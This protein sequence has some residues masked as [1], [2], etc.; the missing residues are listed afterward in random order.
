[1]DLLGIKA[2][3]SDPPVPSAQAWRKPVGDREERVGLDGKLERRGLHVPAAGH[4]AHLTRKLRT[5]FGWEVL[6]DAAGVGEIELI[7][8]KREAAGGVGANERTGVFGAIDDVD[9]G[10][11]EVW[12]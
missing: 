6:D 8:R 9:A 7:V 1:M 10:Y 5:A 12:G 11:V 2:R 3:G 4:A